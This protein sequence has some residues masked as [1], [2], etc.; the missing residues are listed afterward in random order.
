[1]EEQQKH[2]KYVFH[3]ARDRNI[4]PVAGFLAVDEAA[5][6]KSFLLAHQALNTQ[7]KVLV[8]ATVSPDSPA[9]A[10]LLIKVLDICIYTKIWEIWPFTT[11]G[12]YEN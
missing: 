2:S 6:P 1:M 3:L 9:P 10:G 5:N 8:T 7:R 11:L 12:N 4:Q